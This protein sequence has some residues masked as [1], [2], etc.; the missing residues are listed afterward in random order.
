MF[1]AGVSQS[2]CV[3]SVPL[4][5]LQLGMQNGKA[6]GF[7]IIEYAT[8][9]QAETAQIAVNGHTLQ[10]TEIRVTFCI[11]G[12]RAIDIYNKMMTTVVSI[13]LYSVGFILYCCAWKSLKTPEKNV[14]PAEISL[15]Y[16]QAHG[17][18]LTHLGNP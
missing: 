13:V 16:V 7:G 6:L 15:K 11:P 9:D 10:S 1:P 17:M 2:L 12:E 4:S 18:S 3:K 5:I 14:T 8:S